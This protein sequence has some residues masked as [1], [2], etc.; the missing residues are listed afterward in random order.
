MAENTLGKYTRGSEVFTH[1]VWMFNTAVLRQ[2]ATSLLLG[3]F[4]GGAL[5]YFSLGTERPFFDSYTKAAFQ[6]HVTTVNVAEY[7]IPDKGRVKMVVSEAYRTLRTH[8]GGREYLFMLKQGA[9]RVLVMSLMISLLWLV[10]VLQIGFGLEKKKTLRGA[11]VLEIGGAYGRSFLLTLP[12]VLVAAVGA[13]IVAAL[14]AGY[15]VGVWLQI[16]GWLSEL[17][18]PLLALEDGRAWAGTM[19]GGSF[20]QPQSAAFFE[21]LKAQHGGTLPLSDIVWF[22][23]LFFIVVALGIPLLAA[24]LRKAQGLRVA[25]EGELVLG[26]VPIDRHGE[27]YHWLFCGSP[28]SGKSTAIKDMLDQIRARGERAIVYDISGEYIESYYRSGHDS[29]LNPLDARHSAWNIF[30]DGRTEAD[31]TA[32]A[33]AL[34]PSG[35]DSKNEFWNNASVTLFV[36]LA[37]HFKRSYLERLEEGTPVWERQ[38][39]RCSERLFRLLLEGDVQDVSD[40][41]KGTKAANLVGKGA[42]ETSQNLLATIASK[43]GGFASLASEGKP[44]SIREWVNNEDNDKWLFI[45]SRQDMHESLRPLISLFCDVAAAGILSLEP[46]SERRM[47][48]LFDEVASLQKLPSLPA[49]L[50]RGRKHGCAVMLGLQSMPQ[51]QASYGQYPAAALCSQPQNWLILRTVEPNTAKWLSDSIGGAET[52]E[53]QM[54]ISMGA[55]SERDG[56]NISRQ[57]KRESAVLPSEIIGLPDLTGYFILP[58]DRPV[59]RTSYTYKRRESIAEGF[60]EA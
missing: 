37:L 10:V 46:D 40:H 18:F 57:K 49:L 53:A 50:E 60:I 20:A 33:R 17:G 39:R 41:V 56:V 29:I 14:I 34:F 9:S 27:C 6:H 28:G 47:W 16:D 8:F 32:F 15:E 2:I 58:G 31:F 11:T 35:E 19:L 42:A 52:E 59:Y 45:S 12:Q 23:R 13:G 7:T 44:F 26:D 48:V 5:T 51:L 43:L 55:N 38:A 24:R 21:A 1:Y 4:V 3:L 30:I 54:S 25:E 22:W 36:E